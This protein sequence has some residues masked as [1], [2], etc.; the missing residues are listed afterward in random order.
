MYGVY[1]DRMGRD[2]STRAALCPV[3]FLPGKI[4]MNFSK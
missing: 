1:T 3:E 2:V 4:A